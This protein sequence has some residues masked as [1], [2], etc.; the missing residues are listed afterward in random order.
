MKDFI[1]EHLD[2]F[3][4]MTALKEF[5]ESE[6]RNREAGNYEKLRLVGYILNISFDDAIVVTSDPFKKAVGGVPRGSFLIMCPDDFEG[7][8]LHFMLLRVVDTAPTPLSKEVQQTFFELH[9]RSMPELDVWTKAELQWGALKTKILGMFF[10]DPQNPEKIAFSGDVNNLVSPYRYEVFAPN[11]KLL[12]IIVNG[13]VP[14]IKRFKIGKLRLTECMLL[15][16]DENN[17]VDVD[18]KVSTLDFVGKR[19]AMFGKT[20]LGKSNVVK[21]IAESIIKTSEKKIGQLIFDINGEYAND[22]PQDGSKSIRSKYSEHCEVY[23]LTKRPNTPSKPLKINFYL[24]PSEGKQILRSLLERDGRT[25]SQYVKNFASVDLPSFKEI[26]SVEYNE[27]IRFFRKIQIYW[28]ILHQANFKLPSG[29]EKIKPEGISK[30][31]KGFDPGLSKDILSALDKLNSEREKKGKNLV[32]KHP[33]SLDELVE[34]LQVLNSMR[35]K[36]KSSSGKPLFDPDD[37][38]LLD[39]LFPKSGGGPRMLMPYREYHSDKASNFVQEILKY[40]DEGKTVIL[41]LGNAIDE[42]RAYF[43][44]YI[45]REI[46]AHQ[47]KKFVA[48]NLGDHYIQL[49]FEEAHNLFPRDGDYKSIYAR[50]AKEGAKFHIGMVYSTQSPSTIDPEL[51]AQTENFFVAHMSSQKEVEVLAKLQIAF[52]G[53]QQDILKTRTPGYMRILTFSHRFVIPVQI[54]KFET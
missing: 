9:K 43:S 41:D 12:D 49:Y 32:S 6:K 34:L 52:D 10:S 20:R 31:P 37:E 13:L 26:N 5:L 1:K 45:S 42:I 28:A 51:L 7:F 17:Q 14:N 53:L 35:S 40:L 36:L 18:V 54:K 39:F 16:P 22:N 24:Q 23:A 4:C 38:A 11:D 3:S 46:F 33:S 47:E 19:T 50:I 21:V 8:P 25:S 27:K 29:L 30:G 2:S 15:L 44:D 48:N